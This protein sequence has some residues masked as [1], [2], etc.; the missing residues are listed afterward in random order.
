[1]FYNSTNFDG[2]LYDH[3]PEILSET[4]KFRPCHSSISMT[5]DI[6]S[7]IHCEKFVFVSR[8]KNNKWYIGYTTNLPNRILDLKNNPPSFM[9]LHPFEEIVTFIPYN[10]TNRIAL[11]N[12]I[13]RIYGERYG[14]DNVHHT[15]I[16]TKRIFDTTT[17]PRL[18]KTYQLE[19]NS[20]SDFMRMN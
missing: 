6:E 7:D 9:K 2:R 12:R 19:R 5:Y 17:K 15:F 3:V 4:D 13:A 10:D 14:I 1:M 8:C 20:F 18:E 11:M 16:S